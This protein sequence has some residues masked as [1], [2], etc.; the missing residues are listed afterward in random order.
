[1]CWSTEVSLI[2]A[3]YGYLVSL[4][5]YHRKYSVR[6]PWSVEGVATYVVW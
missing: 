3:G 4:Y 1:M 5:L 6:D 2:A